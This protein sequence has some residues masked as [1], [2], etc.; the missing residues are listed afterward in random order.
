MNEF[1]VSSALKNHPNIVQI[2]EIKNQAPI[3][4]DGMEQKRDFMKLE[5]CKNGDLYEFIKAYTK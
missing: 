2:S 5:Y 3:V 4:I 1:N